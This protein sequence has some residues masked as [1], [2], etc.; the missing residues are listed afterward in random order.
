VTGG[1]ATTPAGPLATLLA[2]TWAAI[3]AP[4]LLGYAE[5]LLRRDVA[6]RYGGR[7]AFLRGAA[8]ETA[9]SLL[10]D[11]VST[12]NKAMALTSLAF[13]RRTTWAPQNRADRGV[14][15]AD[16]ARLL[17]PH[18]ALGL[19]LRR[20]ARLGVGG[21]LAMALPFLAGLVLAVPFCVVT[22]AP[23]FSRWLA[24]RGIAATP[25]ELAGPEPP[26]VAAEAVAPAVAP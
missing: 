15:W 8:V 11:A 4:R 21:A 3:V 25:E 20:G 7:A 12:V 18:T 19:G 24:S 9:F 17:W 5:V 6:A 23:G 10:L 14:A 1:G 26:G 22:A 16:A 13:G 2:L